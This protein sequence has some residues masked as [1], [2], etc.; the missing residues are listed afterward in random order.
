MTINIKRDSNIELFRVVTMLTIISHH[1]VVNSGVLNCFD[2][3]NITIKQI[4]LLLIGMW[5]K[6]AI[7]SFVMITGYFMCQSKL[8]F[9]RYAKIFLEA[10]FY[11]VLIYIIFVFA[12]YEIVSKKNLLN[13]VFYL[14]K[15]GNS[16]YTG[17]ILIVYLFIPF[18]NQILERM[19]YQHLKGLL[20]LLIFTFTIK[21]TFFGNSSIF[22]EVFWYITI[23]MIAGFIRLYPPEW[24]KDNHY[25]RKLLLALIILAYLS[26][27]IL[28]FVGSRFSIGAYYMMSDSNKLFPLCIGVLSFLY[29]KNLEIPKMRIINSLGATTFG[30]L[31]IHANSNAM[32]KF[33]WNDLLDIPNLYYKPTIYLVGSTIA[34]PILVF[35][36]C[37]I[38]DYFRIR[39]L[40]RPLFEYISSK[41]KRIN[42]FIDKIFNKLTAE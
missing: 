25:I 42:M 7:N 12:G 1:M 14:L 19:D 28:A 13:V 17:S 22:N 41:E 32:R 2:Y 35:I 29:F 3:S 20:L 5:G 11:F 21:A 40:E 31:L 34:I 6:T 39:F 33:I 10:E 8:T 16:G 30:V 15:S 4:Y 18:L 37:S 9:K 27:V 24:T 23:Y 26:V 36:I 38:L